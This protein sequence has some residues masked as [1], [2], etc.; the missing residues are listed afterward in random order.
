MSGAEAVRLSQEAGRAADALFLDPAFV[1]FQAETQGKRL[2]T[3]SHDAASLTFGGRDGRWASPVTGAFGG[4]AADRPLAAAAVFPLAEALT[5]ELRRTA[6]AQATVRLSPDAY[7]DPNR[8]ALENAL[9]RNGWNLAAA[10]LNYHLPVTAPEAYERGLGETKRKEIRRL[11]RA[12]ARV[13]ALPPAAGKAAYDA[14]A[15]NRAARGFPMTM[16]WPQVEALAAA[17]P[18]RV[19]F[20]VVEREGE[21]LA[22]SI[23]LRVTGDWRYVFYWGEAPDH[24]AASPVTLL[25]LG[26]VAE[27][28]AAGVQVLDIGT[29]TEDSQPNLGL[30][31]F[32][33]SLGCRA[34]SRRTW[35]F[36]G[37]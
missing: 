16:S 8:A 14:I 2:L 33:E 19:D 13:Q 21:V 25:A 32:K 9:F 34:S 26:L 27:S 10:D 4:V 6:G 24:R 18:Q 30:V 22:G 29:A 20:H 15:A 1:R 35:R 31:A 23:S 36:D 17:F 3:A 7:P 37:A 28:H 5:A 12:G 11:Q